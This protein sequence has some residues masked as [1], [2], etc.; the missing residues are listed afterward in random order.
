[1]AAS[2]ARRDEEA[3]TDGSMQSSAERGDVAPVSPR[4]FPKWLQRL[5]SLKVDP[6]LHPRMVAL[7]LGLTLSC[8]LPVWLV[9]SMS[10][11]MRAEL[12]FSLVQLGFAVA[13][14]RGSAALSAPLLSRLPDRIG[15]LR[16]MRLAAAMAAVASVSIALFARDYWTLM[17]CLSLS[18]MSNA[19]GQ[20]SAN[21]A[22]VRAVKKARQGLAFGLK[23]SALPLG[24]LVA[25]V[26]VPLIALTIGWRWA[27]W[28]SAFVAVSIMLLVPRGDS[29]SFPVP[30]DATNT[31]RGGP[32]LTALFFA[33]FL[34]AAAAGSLTT[35]L[36]ESS[37]ASGMRVGVAGLLLAA[38]SFLA[39][40][41]RLIAG[42]MADRRDGGHL[43]VS[44]WMIG[45]GSLGF[46]LIS[47]GS[48]PLITIG[49]L[50]AFCLGWGFPGLFWFAI[51]RQNQANPAQATGVLMPGPMLGGV[52][53]PIVFGAI[54]EASSYRAAWIVAGLSMA[55]AA[56]LMLLGRRLSATAATRTAA[57]DGA[58]DPAASGTAAAD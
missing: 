27:F 3:A 51:V 9:G 8:T 18:G 39:I 12:D 37:V 34:S 1:M 10:V 42:V 47:F 46:L 44:A 55:C 32:A 15:A 28:L 57:A 50:L 23:Q 11:Q 49:T 54:V 21:L 16:A 56:Y 29:S 20:S 35:F 33:L 19:L 13:V 41:T 40:G 31:R 53:G 26:A 14:F 4:A 30:Q 43:R 6:E 52:F 38:G 58:P 17:A 36:V 45:A 24:S 48:I 25:G 7:A 5:N 22:L 2:P